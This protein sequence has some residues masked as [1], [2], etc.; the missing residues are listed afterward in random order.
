MAVAR[1]NS[2]AALR[3]VMYFLFIDVVTFAHSGLYGA[4]TIQLQSATSL[5]RRAHASVLAATC[6]LRRVRD[7]GGRADESVV[8]PVPPGAKLALFAAHRCLVD[9]VV[10]RTT[11]CGAC[12]CGIPRA[13]ASAAAAAAA[14]APVPRAAAAEAAVLF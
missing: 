6:R 4:A 7:D 13:L 10:R 14:S 1:S 9:V 11:G 12:R 8:K 2:L 5:R 3:H